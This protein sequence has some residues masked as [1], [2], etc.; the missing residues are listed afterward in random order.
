MA[1]EQR[2]AA[3]YLRI[4]QDR[5]NTRLGVDRHREDAEALLA[6]RR[7]L[8][9]GVY[10]DNDISGQG[11]KKR[12]AFKRLLGDIESGLIDVVIA[13]EWPRL[14]RNRADGVRIIETAQRHNVL[15]TFAKGSDI[16]CTTA[17]GRLSAD[18]FSAIAR[19]EIEVKAERQSRAQRQRAEQGRPPRVYVLWATPRT[20][21]S[22]STRQKPSGRSTLPS[23]QGR[24]FGRLQRLCPVVKERI[25]LTFQL[26]P[27]TIAP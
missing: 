19:N 26:S 18:M 13:Q 24:R 16:D 17:A 7:W 10:E 1:S 25:F 21:T 27:G 9:V 15:L 3:I 5:E 20:V 12:P 4:S 11:P 14:E 22:S 8:S 2:R 6:A 23:H